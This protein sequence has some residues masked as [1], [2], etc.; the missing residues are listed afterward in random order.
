M[1]SLWFKHPYW[2]W[3]AMWMWFQMHSCIPDNPEIFSEQCQ[4]Q[5][6]PQP[7]SE[8]GLLAAAT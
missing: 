2:S 4:A 8:Q 5:G 3:V 7:F 6:H 1:E